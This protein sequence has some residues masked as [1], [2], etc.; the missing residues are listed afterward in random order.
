[1]KKTSLIL[2][3]LLTVIMTYGNLS[4]PPVRPLNNDD[5]LVAFYPFNG[6]A[7]DESGNEHDGSVTGAIL[8]T[9]RFNQSG[10]AYSFLYNGFSS[11]RI[12]V[13]GT[14]DLNFATGGFSIS[15]WIKFAND[16]SIGV[17]YPIFSKH[18]CNQ[19]LLKPAC[20]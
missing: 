1:M 7:N 6:N 19:L 11:D 4:N 12:E 15:A 5:S 18:I 10:K 3:L 16:G 14:S 13:S 9:D 2:V 17:N 20:A 8:T